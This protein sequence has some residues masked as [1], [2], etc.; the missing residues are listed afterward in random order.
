[1]MNNGTSGHPDYSYCNVVGQT[2]VGRKRSANE[3]HG[4]HFVTING[5]VS[6]VCDGMGGHVGGAVASEVAIEAIQEFLDSTYFDDPRI[7]IGEAIDIANKAVLDRAEI[8]PEL[9]GMGSTCVLLI[10]RDEKVYIGHVGDSRIYLVREKRI[11]QL[12]KD[13]SYVQTLVD[14]GHITKEEAERHPRKNEI[15]NALGLENMIPA[16]VRSEPIEPQAGDCF[17]L[18]SDGLSGMISDKAIERIVSK[19]REYTSQQRADLLVQAANE[20]GGLDNITVEIVEFAVTPSSRNTTAK[21]QR[22]LRMLYISVG[23]LVLLCAGAAIRLLSPEVE[24]KSIV[25]PDITVKGGE[26]S[27][28]FEL[29]SKDGQKWILYDINSQQI[30]VLSDVLEDDIVSNIDMDRT[31]KF[32]FCAPADC[33]LTDSISIT[34]PCKK[35][36]KTY[37]AKLTITPPTNKHILKTVTFKSGASIATIEKSSDNQSVMSFTGE[38]NLVILD[39]NYIF[40]VE[41]KELVNTTMSHNKHTISFVRK[42]PQLPLD[43]KIIF[44][45]EKDTIQYIIPVEKKAN[46]ATSIFPEGTATGGASHQDGSPETKDKGIKTGDKDTLGD[47]KSTGIVRK[48]EETEEY[49]VEPISITMAIPAYTGTITIRSSSISSGDTTVEI[50]PEIDSFVADKVDFGELRNYLTAQAGEDGSL[51]L[52]FKN[53]VDKQI[54][55]AKIIIPCRFKDTKETTLQLALNIRK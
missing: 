42:E 23:L 34:I 9:F 39:G 50:S 17:L 53:E 48:G 24:L 55:S 41:P 44:A 27:V 51:L 1:M 35:V 6:V 7:A 11:L 49:Q 45:S 12:T 8:Q 54:N 52:I 33:F 30:D 28:L 5:L 38:N 4:K 37:S 40:L 47:N 15:T 46:P 19:Q 10:V 18:C 25:L 21:K 3:D 43:I 29:I 2:D 22:R 16:T 31:D 36:T 13:H 14:M 32:R 20:G 26:T